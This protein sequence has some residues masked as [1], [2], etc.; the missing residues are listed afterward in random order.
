[1]SRRWLGKS[2]MPLR[3]FRKILGLLLPTSC[4]YCNSSVGDSGIPFFCTECWSDF[5]VMTGPLCPHCGR[6]FDSP[7]A[8][9]DSPNHRC[10][11]CRREPPVFDQALSAGHFEGPLREAIHQFKYRPCRSLGAP[12]G[13]WLADC[14]IPPN[15]ID[16]II[17]VPL[18]RSRL[19]QRGFN[20]SL[21][22][23]YALSSRFGIPLCYDNLIRTRPTKP[24]VELSGAERIRNV[25]GAFELSDR[26]DVHGRSVLLVDDVFTTGA[27]MN[28]CARVLREAE[29]AHVSVLTVARA[30]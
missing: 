2:I 21:L 16:L 3:F 6:P 26:A 1:M 29:A 10:L 4:S 24:Q 19:R 23:A 8:L 28:E 22:L 30:V 17:P 11:E 18:H 12:L 5:S 9:Q 20:Q 27:T 13:R 14:I 15:G 7:E 25:A